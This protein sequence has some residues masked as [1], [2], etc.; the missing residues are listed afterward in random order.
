MGDYFD[1]FPVTI[2]KKI[3]IPPYSV[4]RFLVRASLPDRIFA[5]HG[6]NNMGLLVPNTLVAGRSHIPI[7]LINDQHRYVKFKRGHIIRHV[8][9]CEVMPD[10]TD[11]KNLH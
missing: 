3:V 6:V 11:S 9:E 8:I 4:V 1:I 2:D 10:V 7:Q 5:V